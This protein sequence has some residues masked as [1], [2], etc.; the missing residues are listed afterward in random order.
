MV[1]HKLFLYIIESRLIEHQEVSI[2]FSLKLAALKF[3]LSACYSRKIFLDTLFTEGVDFGTELSVISIS[4]A[5]TFSLRK[6]SFEVRSHV[7]FFDLA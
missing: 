2:A 4:S 6:K 3:L 1:Q 7:L 5:V